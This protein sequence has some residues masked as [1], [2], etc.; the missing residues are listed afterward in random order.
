MKYL[1][2]HEKIG[3]AT[4]LSTKKGARLCIQKVV[5]KRHDIEN[6]TISLYRVQIH[7]PKRL[8]RGLPGG[9]WAVDLVPIVYVCVQKSLKIPD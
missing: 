5:E 4:N 1:D 8:K 3:K 2:F 7:P 9:G 6:I